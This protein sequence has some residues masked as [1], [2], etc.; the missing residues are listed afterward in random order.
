MTHSMNSL[1][2]AALI[3]RLVVPFLQETYMVLRRKPPNY[4]SALQADVA[5]YVLQTEIEGICVTSVGWVDITFWTEERATLQLHLHF[6]TDVT[7]QQRQYFTDQC[8]HVLRHYPLLRHRHE[9]ASQ[10]THL[11]HLAHEETGHLCE[12]CLSHVVFKAH[13]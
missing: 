4:L 2:I 9:S 12:E 13:R 7:L 10:K 6:S 11:L 3:M 8:Y 5:N 1:F